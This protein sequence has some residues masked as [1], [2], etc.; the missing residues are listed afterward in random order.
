VWTDHA[1]IVR[2]LIEARADLNIKA[3]G[4]RTALIAAVMCGAPATVRM[5]VNAGASKEIVDNNGHDV[6]WHLEHSAVPQ[7][8]KEA[9][10]AALNP[11]PIP[12]NPKGFCDFCKKYSGGQFILCEPCGHYFHEGCVRQHVFAENHY[13]CPT[14]H[15]PIFFAEK[16]F[17]VPMSGVEEKKE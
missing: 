5:L 13:E 4:G 11:L 8:R 3:D 2:L 16:T 1:E 14:C 7:V 6:Y 17:Y 9:V 15:A 12:R 10:R